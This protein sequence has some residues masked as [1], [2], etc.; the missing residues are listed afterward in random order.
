MKEVMTVRLDSEIKDKLDQLAKAT[1]RSKSFLVAAAIRDYIKLYEWQIHAIQ[2]GIRQ[3]N[4]GELI[5]HEEIAMK[6]EKKLENS[7]DESSIQ[8]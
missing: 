2:E 1:A 5:A 4:E 3:A 6:W 7:V 8:L